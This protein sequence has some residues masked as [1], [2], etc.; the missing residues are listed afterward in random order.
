MSSENQTGK[1]Y[2]FLKYDSKVWEA[3]DDPPWA[4]I[5]NCDHLRTKGMCLRLNLSKY[6]KIAQQ[7]TIHQIKTYGNI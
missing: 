6:S 7:Y 1:E 5:R 2:G 3:A 4:E